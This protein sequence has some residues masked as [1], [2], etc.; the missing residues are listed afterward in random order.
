VTS[1]AGSDTGAVTITATVYSGRNLIVVGA[2][3]KDGRQSI[4]ATSNVT[5]E[6]PPL[7]NGQL[8]ELASHQDMA[9]DE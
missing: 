4:G 5:R 3:I 6:V 8:M 7:G 9:I 2:S 1:D